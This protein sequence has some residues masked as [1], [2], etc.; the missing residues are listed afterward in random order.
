MERFWSKVNKTGGCWEWTAAANVKGYGRFMFEGRV[1]YAHR[2]SYAFAFGGI[3]EGL[4]VCHRCDNP[5]CVNP[6]HLFLGTNMDNIQDCCA[7]G[8]HH[9]QSATY[10][11]NGHEYTPETTGHNKAG[12]ICLICRRITN[13]ASKAARR[14]RIGYRPKFM[15]THCVHGHE[16]TPE[17]TINRAVGQGRQ[18]R[19]CQRAANIASKRKRRHSND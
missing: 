6:A 17:N 15:S 16:F 10:C 18:C 8:R 5:K 9:K 19:T 2:L 1:Q 3:S 13:N 11:N 7:K 12:R 14:A 4:L